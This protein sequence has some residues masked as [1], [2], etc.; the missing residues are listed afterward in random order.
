MA[1]HRVWMSEQNC[2]PERYFVLRI[3]A[4]SLRSPRRRRIEFRDASSKQTLLD[5]HKALYI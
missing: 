3:N 1:P 2:N 4:K 5:M